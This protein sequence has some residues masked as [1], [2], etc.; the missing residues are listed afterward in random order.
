M[1]PILA[2]KHEVVPVLYLALPRQVLS[3]ESR[4]R[5][6]PLLWFFGVPTSITEPTCTS[7]A[8][9]DLCLIW[10]AAYSRGLDCARDALCRHLGNRLP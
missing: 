6:H 4:K 1:M 9:P 7:A 3:K 10:S 5:D 8:L 2:G